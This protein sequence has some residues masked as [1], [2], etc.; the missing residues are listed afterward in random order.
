[1]LRVRDQLACQ[2]DGGLVDHAAL[3][4]H[5][6]T[7]F[8]LSGFVGPNHLDRAFDVLYGR[9]EHLIDGIDLGR[10]NGPFAVT[11]K[12]TRHNRGTA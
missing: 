5:C 11:S 6:A 9:R 7:T 2:P 12:C 3:D 1:M 8:L 4:S 10:M